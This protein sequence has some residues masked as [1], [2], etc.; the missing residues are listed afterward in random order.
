MKLNKTYNRPIIAGLALSAVA[1]AV[2]VMAM[3]QGGATL[4]EEPDRGSIR[5][6]NDQD[7]SN[8]AKLAILSAA[9]AEQAVTGKAPGKVIETELEVEHEFLVWEVKSVANDGTTTELYV[10]AGNGEILAMEQEDDEG[11][12]EGVEDEDHQGENEDEKDDGR[13]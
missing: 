11:H 1:A 13:G 4:P 3:A 6:I 2:P 5:V 12:D 7:E 9:Q 8:L 10:D